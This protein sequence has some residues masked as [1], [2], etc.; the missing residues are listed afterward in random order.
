ML[1]NLA[2]LVLSKPTLKMSSRLLVDPPIMPSSLSALASKV[3]KLALF[4][5]KTVFLVP[6]LPSHLAFQEPRKMLR[7]QLRCVAWLKH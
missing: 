2:T 3:L 5:S 7:K 4:L 1:S 6:S